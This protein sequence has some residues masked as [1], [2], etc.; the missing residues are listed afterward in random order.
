M[1]KHFF[2]AGFLSEVTR[3]VTV[4]NRVIFSTD[5]PVVSIKKIESPKEVYPDA[6]K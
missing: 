5:K 6:R 3:F 4:K 1:I 2:I